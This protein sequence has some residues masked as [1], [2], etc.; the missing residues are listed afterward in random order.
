LYGVTSFI[1]YYITATLQHIDKIKQALGVQVKPEFPKTI[2]AHS[3]EQQKKKQK[4]Q[5][6]KKECVEF[7]VKRE[8]NP[9]SQHCPQ[10]AYIHVSMTSEIVPYTP[11][12]SIKRT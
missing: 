8:G 12:K 4:K 5:K 3:P 11:F 6:P 9:R 7:V 10:V 1:Y 2:T